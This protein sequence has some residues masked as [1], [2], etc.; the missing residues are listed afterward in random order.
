LGDYRTGIKEQ[1]EP[2]I[3]QL[4]IVAIMNG[5]LFIFGIIAIARGNCEAARA[6]AAEVALAGWQNIA[7]NRMRR[8]D[9][10]HARLLDVLRRAVIAEA[11]LARLEAVIARTVNDNHLDD[12][13]AAAER[14]LDTAEV[15]K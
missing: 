5:A 7:E 10:G 3:I 12:L 13:V 6:N 9:E 2:N 15:A 11:S 1:M 4:L 14:A 8:V